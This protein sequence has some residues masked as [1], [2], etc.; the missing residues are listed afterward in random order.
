MAKKKAKKK[1]AAKKAAKRK[2]KSTRPARTEVESHV[3][4]KMAKLLDSAKVSGGFSSFTV[5]GD[6]VGGKILAIESVKARWGP[7]KKVTVETG[8]GT[9]T[10]F[11]PTMLDNFFN[12]HEVAVGDTIGVRYE[13]LAPS[14]KG[15]DAKLFKVVHQKGNG[16]K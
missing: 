14:T 10:F 2:Q 3:D 4:S 1:G 9:K 5:F 6:S 15:A 8:E 12:E 7:Q 11:C 13:A 16:Q